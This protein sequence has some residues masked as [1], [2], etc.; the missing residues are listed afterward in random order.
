MNNNVHQTD[1][2]SSSSTIGNVHLSCV[3]EFRLYTKPPKGNNQGGTPPTRDSVKQSFW[4]FDT[5][6]H[7]AT[8]AHAC[9]TIFFGGSRLIGF[10][11][12]WFAHNVHDVTFREKL[13]SIVR[14]IK[15][16]GYVYISILTNDND[17][18]QISQS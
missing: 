14:I 2:K 13:A 7:D 12:T 5:W 10:I 15:M 18:V 8:V 1:I 17:V 16:M 11:Q 4:S 3:H 9:V 6:L